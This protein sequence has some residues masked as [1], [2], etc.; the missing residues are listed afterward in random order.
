MSGFSTRVSACCNKNKTI[1]HINTS[2]NISQSLRCTYSSWC[3]QGLPIF[4]WKTSMRRNAVSTISWRK[5]ICLCNIQQQKFSTPPPVLLIVPV[6]Y[7]YRLCWT[8]HCAAINRIRRHCLAI[9]KYQNPDFS[10][11]GSRIT[12]IFVLIVYIFKCLTYYGSNL[13][14]WLFIDL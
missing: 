14:T 3:W 8:L 6:T 12:Y 2:I 13:I 5:V 1:F 7:C 9:T 11:S 10:L 4:P